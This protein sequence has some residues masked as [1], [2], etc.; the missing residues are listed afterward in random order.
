MKTY[1]LQNSHNIY[2]LTLSKKYIATKLNRGS[3]SDKTL[4]TP[5][6]GNLHGYFQDVFVNKICRI[7]FNIKKSYD[8]DFEAET[9]I[10]FSSSASVVVFDIAGLERYT[11]TK[12][13]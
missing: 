3:E 2:S 6:F 9:L 11:F 5:F 12:S 7:F 13:I 4:N 1:K 8:H 10:L